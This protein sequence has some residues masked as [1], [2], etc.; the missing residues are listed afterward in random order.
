MNSLDK[1]NTIFSVT[2]ETLLGFGTCLVAPSTILA[3]LLRKYH[4]GETM[5]GSLYGIEWAGGLVP[6]ILGLYIFTSLARRKK[7]LMLWTVLVIAPF[8]ILMGLMCRAADHVPPAVFRWAMLFG[9]VGYMAGW[10]VVGG[11]WSDWWAHVYSRE[12]RGT[13]TGLAWGFGSLAGVAASL[14]SGWLL[15]HSAEVAMYSNIYLL[16]GTFLALAWLLLYRIDDS[17]V[18]TAEGSPPITTRLLLDRFKSSIKDTNFRNF[19]I[20]RLFTMAGFCIMPLIAVNFASARGGKLSEATIV[21]LSACLTAGAAVANVF[22]GLLGDRYGHRLGILLGTIMQIPTL[23]VLLIIPGRLGCLLAYAGAGICIGSAI[24]SF[25]NMLFE[26]CPHDHGP[27]HITIG[28]LLVGLGT[29]VFSLVGGR[30]AE[31]F[32]LSVFF[33]LC[34][35]TSIIAFLWTWLRVREPR[36]INLIPEESVCIESPK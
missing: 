23:L 12:V 7:Q 13:V 27:A 10:G 24:V 26:T 30:M 8:L 9:A 21:T 22:L 11:V 5:I 28:S 17:A 20:G 36:D 18:R 32:G 4:A 33:G 3:L 34:L 1:R 19:I 2:G 14:F 29:I 15:K 31:I 35:V 6:Q 25:N 16:G